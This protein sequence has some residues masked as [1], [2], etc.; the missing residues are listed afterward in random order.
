M[1]M[2]IRGLKDN[3]GDYLKLYVEKSNSLKLK[4]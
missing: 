1:D 4:I 3:L 2:I